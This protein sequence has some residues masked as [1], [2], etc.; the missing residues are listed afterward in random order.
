M[1]LPKLLGI[2]LFGQFLDRRADQQLGV[3]R[4]HR[5]VFVGAWK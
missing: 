1:H 3:A 5:R 4:E 2:E